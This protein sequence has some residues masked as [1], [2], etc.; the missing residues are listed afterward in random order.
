[1]EIRQFDHVKQYPLFALVEGVIDGFLRFADA[2]GRRTLRH[3][4]D[5]EVI[6]VRDAKACVPHEAQLTGQTPMI[7]WSRPLIAKPIDGHAFETSLALNRAYQLIRL[8]G[9]EAAVKAVSKITPPRLIIFE[10][11]QYAGA[12][13]TKMQIAVVVVY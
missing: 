11:T 13:K 9:C 6:D 5:A 10:L 2:H 7:N 12:I 4:A 8:A 3:G 1:M